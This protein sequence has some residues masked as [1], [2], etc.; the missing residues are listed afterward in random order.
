MVTPAAELQAIFARIS[1]AVP[2]MAKIEVVDP[3]APLRRGFVRVCC[4]SDTH[5]CHWQ[6][7]IPSGV[8]VLMHGGDFTMKGERETLSDFLE[9]L[10]RQEAERKVVI[11][12][13]HEITLDPRFN[14]GKSLDPEARQWL[15]DQAS[16]TY[17]EHEEAIIETSRGRLKV[18]GSPITPAHG[19]WAFQHER[20][21]EMAKMWRNVQSDAQL[22]LVHGPPQG[23][24]DKTLSGKRV[25]DESF[26][27]A[28]ERAQHPLA[29]IF[30]HIHED[31]GVTR[32]GD[33]GSVFVNC[34]SVDILYQPVNPPI[35]LDV[36]ALTA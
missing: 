11:A 36:P 28:L 27:A 9:W 18:F 14:K 5:G 15:L 13:N 30:G 26:R 25:G 2:S 21:A 10:R 33:D 23:F 29:A 19:F 35:L 16:F 22:W 20:G 7:P 17:L 1:C 12:G 34:S 24:Q 4:L 32:R 31:Y 8:D 6:V 3:S